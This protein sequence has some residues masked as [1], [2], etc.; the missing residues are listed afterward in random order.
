MNA[1]QPHALYPNLLSPL[2]VGPF[3]IRNRTLMGSMH[4]GLEEQIGPLT[5]LA[6]YARRRAEGGAGII[7]TGGFAPNIE[8]WVKP[9]AG[10][11]TNR[12][13]AY[14]HRVIPDAV[15]DAG[16]RIVL[17]ILHSGRYG[18]HPF[19]VAPS[20]IQSPIT[21]FKP[22]ALSQRGVLK[23]IKDFARCAKLAKDAGYDGVEVMGSEGY[24]I[25]EF[26]V[27]RTNK[28]TD[29]WGG[30]YANR[31]RFP[32]EILKA[33][34]EACGDDFLVIYRLSMLDLVEDGSTFDE[35]VQLA[36]AVQEAGANVINTGIGW[37]EARVPTIATSVPRAGF[38]WVTKRL[39]P[40]IQVPLVTSNRINMPDVAEKVLADDVAD[41]VSMARPFLADPD[42]VRKAQEERAEDI[43]TCIACNQ[44]CLDHAFE[45]KVA[46]CLVNPVAGHELE[47]KI[48]PTRQRRKV[49]VVGAGPAG[50]AAS[51]TA[52]ER[53]HEVVLFE[54]AS[55]IGGQFNMAKQVPGKEEF[56]ETIRYFGRRLAQ[57]GVDL[58]LDTRV[59]PEDLRD[60]DVVLVATGVTPRELSLPGIDHDKVVS[61]VDVL[62]GRVEVGEKVAVIGA[63]GIGHDVSVFLA[64]PRPS[65]AE[66]P[67]KF[68]EAWGIAVQAWGTDDATPRGGLK[69]K[70]P[71]QALR[72]VTMCQRSKGKM[73][74]GLGK[75]TGWIHRK[76]LD[77]L[78]VD[79]LTGVSYERIDDAGLHITVD[80]QPRV[81]EADHVVIC[82]GQLPLDAL[83][84][85]LRAWG[86]EAHAI[87]GADEARELDA[88][89]A[90]DQG[91]RL[92]ARI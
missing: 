31:M 59:A 88:K 35:V 57:A 54:A 91:T 34:R 83:V 78:G 86:I 92:A 51:C 22:R 11:L 36:G 63:G 6:A 38:A 87:G 67:A 9:L 68:A 12:W 75:T 8:G 30:E 26:L 29:A 17:Q 71:H 33:V 7:V 4:V 85:P 18:Y 79:K 49:A 69:D 13:E 81:I 20:A 53:G 55:E 89:R 76:E 56:H 19:S 70:S 61:Y 77:H 28:R 10:K 25:N 82:A 47:L 43:N 32:V 41:I 46:S 62:K 2:D 44:A 80:G 24:L 15:H 23:Q 64:E 66:D 45:N 72:Q 48:H 14:K 16:G 40:H 1:T 50:L 84:A 58:R 74:S 39:R 73:G 21:P 90:I 60:F 65:L 37:H 52:A 42:W 3:T 5:K 27:R